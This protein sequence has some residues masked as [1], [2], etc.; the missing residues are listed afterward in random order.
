M[1]YKTDLE[2]YV[3][4]LYHFLDLYQLDGELMNDIAMKLNIELIHS[5]FSSQAVRMNGRLTINLNLK[6]ERYEDQWETF[7]HELCHVLNDV[8]NQSALPTQ[9]RQLRERKARNF[10]LHFCIP[11]FMLDKLSWPDG[12]AIPY[13]AEKFHVTI[14]F[15]TER[16]DQYRNRVMQSQIDDYAAAVSEPSVSYHI[17]NCSSETRRIIEQLRIQ[18]NRKGEHLEIKSLL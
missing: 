18:L 12:N 5:Q 10:A 11:T 1:Y 16:L 3:E 15:A 2:D 4:S 7:G 14:P 9:L 13:V 8:G 17:D 6:L